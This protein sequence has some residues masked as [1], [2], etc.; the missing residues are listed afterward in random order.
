MFEKKIETGRSVQ[1]MIA[2]LETGGMNLLVAVQESSK[3]VLLS[4]RS[5]LSPAA[6]DFD[7]PASFFLCASFSTSE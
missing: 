1:N 5:I 6:K 2:L 3:I 4:I 7:I